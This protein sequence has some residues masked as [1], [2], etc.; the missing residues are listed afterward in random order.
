MFRP[1]MSP[2]RLSISEQSSS[3]WAG[4]PETRSEEMRAATTA[5]TLVRCLRSQSLFN[6]PAGGGAEE[7]PG[8]ELGLGLGGGKRRETLE[9][10]GKA[11]VLI[12]GSREWRW[13]EMEECSS[14]QPTT[15]TRLTG[16][17]R[18]SSGYSSIF[19]ESSSSSLSTCFLQI[20][21]ASSPSGI[22]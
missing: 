18:I 19:D 15:D 21:I 1:R 7:S 11:K 5:G 2:L 9:R 20:Q 4:S 17:L 13:V 16:G 3:H 8:P 22:P 12:G 6:M 14:E 10:S